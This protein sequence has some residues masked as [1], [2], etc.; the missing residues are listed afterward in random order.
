MS[1]FT[2]DENVPMPGRRNL[3]PFETMKAG[4]SF[5]ITG[6]EEARKVRNAAYQFA[7]KVNSAS[8]KAKAEGKTDLV[9]PEVKFALRK[10]GEHDT[11]AK[12]PEGKDITVKVY[13]LWREQV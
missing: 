7:K 11:G 5:E 8:E 3:Y 6:E 9:L 4:Q 2:I 12:D 1:N 10:T 13:R